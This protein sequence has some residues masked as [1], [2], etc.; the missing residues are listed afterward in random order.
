MRSAKCTYRS[1]VGHIS[2]GV[3]MPG[4]RHV[5][6]SQTSLK[7]ALWVSCLQG[8]LPWLR[9]S[10]WS[11]MSLVARKAADLPLGAGF[12]SVS[13]WAQ[14]QSWNMFYKHF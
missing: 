11:L 3:Q 1:F 2:G 7:V 6:G 8:L 12:A 4:V 5:S 10:A 14:G 9:F 13:F